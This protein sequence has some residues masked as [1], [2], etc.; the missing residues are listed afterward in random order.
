MHQNALPK[1][2]GMNYLCIAEY[3][4]Q[5]QQN[6][7]SKLH[8]GYIL[9]L[10]NMIP[11]LFQ[12]ELSKQMEKDSLTLQNKLHECLGMNHLYAADYHSGIEQK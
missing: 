8:R 10:K 2:F 9:V 7:S 6:L 12:G 11:D 4:T 1:H 5:P 3:N